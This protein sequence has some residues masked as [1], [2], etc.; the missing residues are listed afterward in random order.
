MSQRANFV[1][2]GVRN[3]HHGFTAVHSFIMQKGFIAKLIRS[4]SP[5]TVVLSL[6]FLVMKE[7]YHR[8]SFKGNNY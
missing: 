3:V 2:Y 8:G 5:L 4:N 1:A 6:K 7:L